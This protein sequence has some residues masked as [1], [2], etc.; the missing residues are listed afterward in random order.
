M[1]TFQLPSYKC[2]NTHERDYFEEETNVNDGLVSMN[3]YHKIHHHSED[4]NNWSIYQFRFPNRQKMA[5]IVVNSMNLI[6][7]HKSL[8]SCEYSFSGHFI[9][10]NCDEKKKPMLEMVMKLVWMTLF[11][12]QFFFL[13][14]G[15]ICIRCYTMIKWPI[16]W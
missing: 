3:Q 13:P 16:F 2:I 14:V 6:G 1:K 11:H 12:L 4:T 8:H 15:L 5:V 9:E 10:F 7:S